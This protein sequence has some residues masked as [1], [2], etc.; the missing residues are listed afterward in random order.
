MY[1]RNASDLSGVMR[2]IQRNASGSVTG[3]VNDL[4]LKR[5][6]AKNVAFLQQL[7]DIGKLRRVDAEERRLHL[8]RLIERQVVAVH[9]HGCARVLMKFA[10]AADVID[11][12][13]RA[14]DG[15]YDELMTAEKVQD[16]IY[17]VAGVHH[18]RFVRH[19]I[20]DDRTIALQHPYGD[21]DMDQS[22][23]RG[24]ENRSAVAH[25]GQYTIGEE[26]IRRRRSVSASDH[27]LPLCRT[28]STLTSRRPR[29]MLS[30]PSLP[31]TFILPFPSSLPS[32]FQL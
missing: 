22:L 5:S 4:G 31:A 26:G 20:A 13:V 27:L 2:D 18:Q 12:R 7:I 14:D 8:H 11:V 3:C 23:S 25:E 19:R 30:S 21:G 16:A 32:C 28:R 15:L 29:G 1:C 24:I 17:F 9:Q 10:Q 6:P